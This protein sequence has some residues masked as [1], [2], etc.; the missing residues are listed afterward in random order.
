MYINVMLC[1]IIIFWNTMTG[2]NIF[3][4]I[5]CIGLVLDVV[6]FFFLFVPRKLPVW[7]RSYVPRFIYLTEKAW[8]YYPYTETGE[9][10]VQVGLSQTQRTLA[11]VYIL[12]LRKCSVEIMYLQKLDYCTVIWKVSYIFVY[13]KVLICNL[14][15]CLSLHLLKLLLSSQQFQ[16]SYIVCD[17]RCTFLKASFSSGNVD[18]SFSCLATSY[19]TRVHGKII[20]IAVVPTAFLMIGRNKLTDRYVND[21]EVFE[22]FCRICV[23]E[24]KPLQQVCPFI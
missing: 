7:I 3:G 13:R 12:D 24:V 6:F 16:S 17:I 22:T 2:R 1:V 19:L 20:S 10:Q 9:V 4:T 14:C 18:L 5:Y 15:D 11:I 23:W 8:N 21:C